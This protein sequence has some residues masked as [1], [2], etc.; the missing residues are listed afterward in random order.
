[1]EDLTGVWLSMN[2][3]HK[4]HQQTILATYDKQTIARN[5]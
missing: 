3:M 5:G 1:M 4:L 2:G